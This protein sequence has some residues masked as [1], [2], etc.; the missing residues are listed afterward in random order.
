LHGDGKKLLVKDLDIRDI[1]IIDAM[2]VYDCPKKILIVGCGAGRIDWHLNNMGYEVY[3][4]DVISGKDFPEDMDFYKSD[5][6]DVN[7][8]PINKCEIVICSQVLEHLRDYKTALK[9][10]LKLTEIR[11]IITVPYKMS[12][13]SPGHYNHW[14]DKSVK[15]FESICKPYV[16]SISKI[17]TKPKDVKLNQ[18]CYLIIIDKRQKYE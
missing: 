12:F 9:N 11:L 4:T 18:W 13:N 7:S 1:S 5:I 15:E 14:D 17:R 10:L 6:F 3:S 16:I 2:P 8:F